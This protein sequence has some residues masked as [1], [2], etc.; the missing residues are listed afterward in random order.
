MP[1]P[2]C[3]HPRARDADGR[4]L[5]QQ[6]RRSVP[7]VHR[8]RARCSRRTCDRLVDAS[9]SVAGGAVLGWHPAL[10][11]RNIPVLRGRRPP[12]RDTFDDGAARCRDSGDVQRDLLLH[13]VESPRFRR[14]FPGTEPPAPPSP[15]AASRASSPNMLRRYA[16]RIDD[17]D[18]REHA[19]QSLVKGVCPDCEGT[20]L[21][22]ES[23]AVTVLGLNIV[24]AARTA[25]GRTGRL[26]RRVGGPRRR[27][28]M[29]LHRARRRRS[30]GA[31]APSRRRRRRLSDPRAGDAQPLRR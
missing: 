1:C 3:S 25:A 10:A 30:A 18:Y 6:A 11:R 14:H 27:G 16:E 13:G 17:A 7:F 8:P 22:P 12:L 28:R 23:R 26:D 21:R 2:H 20:R 19:E 29:A 4:L 15:P 5:L 9:R 24:D 31:R